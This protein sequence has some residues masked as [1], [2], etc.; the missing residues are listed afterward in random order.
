MSTPANQAP[1]RPHTPRRL[2]PPDQLFEV[3]VWSEANDVQPAKWSTVAWTMTRIDADKVAEAYVRGDAH[4]PYA[5]VWVQGR[6]V[7][8]HTRP[9]G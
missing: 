9:A 4:Y 3:A 5:E 1:D 8:R 6:P 7:V 2:P